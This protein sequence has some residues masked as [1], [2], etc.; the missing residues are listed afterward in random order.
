MITKSLKYLLAFTVGCGFAAAAT[1]CSDFLYDD[2]DQVAYADRNLLT[3]DADTLWAVAGIMNKMQVIADRTILLG[4][5]RGDLVTLT[6]DAS[7]DLRALADFSLTASAGT[8]SAS[9]GLPAGTRSASGGL[10]AGT[11]SKYDQ[12]RDYYAVINNCNY[13]LANADT[14]LRNSRNER[15]FLKEYAAVKAFRAWTYLQL[16]LNYRRVPL[17]TEPVLSMEDA[18]KAFPEAGIEEVC[19]YFISDLA[20][21]ADVETPTYGAIRN[22]DSKLFYYPVNVLLG[23]LYLWSGQ[24]R[25]AAKSY[26]RYIS[27]RNGSN[28]AYPLSTSSVRFYKSDSRWMSTVDDWSYMFQQE[29]SSSTG[30]II[31]MIPGDSIPSEGN[32]SEL[33]DLFNTSENNDYTCSIVPSQ[34]IISLSAAQKYCHYTSGGEYVFAPEGLSNYRSGDLRLSAVYTTSASGGLPA[35]TTVNGKRIDNYSIIGKYQTR[36][37]HI[38]RRAMVYLRLAEA[39]NRA[40]FPRFAF[41]ILKTGVN[42]SVIAQHVLPYYPADS[43]FIASFNFPNT[44]YVLETTAGM[45]TENTMGLH[46]RGSGYTAANDSYAFLE[47]STLIASRPTVS[48]SEILNAQT[49][50]VEDLL[51]DEEA[52]EF[53]FEGHR[54]YD[55]MRIALRRGDPAYLADRVARRSGVLDASLQSLLLNTDN[56]YLKLK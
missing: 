44:A 9:G 20:P 42:N 1:S 11:T 48:P 14:T 3:D 35:G 4:E 31:T 38:L 22:T 33:R 40:G 41:Q 51:T 24:Y 17:I 50:Y 56:W 47:D 6:S 12:P 21:Y 49:E 25:E 23:D 37:V 16:V 18:E 55:L 15:V 36:N 26:Y 45:A 30:E 10:P 13:Y 8:R 2:S 5:V 43:A 27:T 54:F 39:L 53:A 28:S 34:A 19:R 46:S 29:S 7:A 32:Y 52:L